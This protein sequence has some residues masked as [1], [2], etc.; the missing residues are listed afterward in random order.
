MQMQNQR[1]LFCLQKSMNGPGVHV[2]ISKKESS[3]PVGVY[4]ICRAR[5][6]G[7]EI[8]GGGGGQKWTSTLKLIGRQ[9]NKCYEEYKLDYSL[10][11]LILS[12]LE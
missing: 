6:R 2:M 9:S 4:L 11:A 12:Y 8:Y 3:Y 5:I 10:F 7:T 1:K